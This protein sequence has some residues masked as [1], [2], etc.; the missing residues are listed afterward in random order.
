LLT[1]TFPSILP[2]APYTYRRHEE[3]PL[4]KH[5]VASTV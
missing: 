2:S 1:F 3:L 5:A 4:R